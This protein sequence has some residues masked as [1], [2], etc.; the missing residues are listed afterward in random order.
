MTRVLLV[1]V[2]GSPEP[3]L[4]TAE[5][6]QPDELIFICSAPP[7]PAPSLD[8]VIGPGTPCLHVDADGIDHWRPN[9]V[10]QLGLTDFHADHQIIALADPD[11]LVAIHQQ[12]Q[13][14]C[15]ELKERFSQLELIGDYSGGTKSMSAALAMVLVD[16][17]A[18]IHL[19]TGS[20][21]NLVRLDRSDGSRPIAIGPLKA[22]RLLNDQWPQLLAS[23]FYD[24]AAH[25]LRELRLMHQPSLDPSSLDAIQ[26]LEE[27]L[28]VLMLWDQFHWQDAL[29][30]ATSSHVLNEFPELLSWWQRVDAARALLCK[31]PSEVAATGY[32]LVQDLLLNADRRGRRGWYD[33]AVAR[34]YRALEL[35]AQTYIQLELGID[36][37]SF[38]DD[39]QVQRDCQQWKIRR[40]VGGLYYWLRQ[41]EG[42]TGL[43]GAAG[44]Q[45]FQLRDLLDARNHSLLSHGLKPIRQAD[46]QALQ[47]RVNNLVTRALQ[48]AGC[49]Q[50]APPHQL[51]ADLILDLPQTRLLLGAQP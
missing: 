9:L 22:S 13:R 46:W 39:D 11:D 1:T 10:H 20:R 45:W 35:L 28:A 24:R 37:Q 44:R 47:G 21:S 25:S 40:G 38:W 34:L 33:D 41:T 23:H 43:G 31:E 6:H 29:E 7:C 19:V 4:K 32:E 48:E 12:V 5:I 3:I 15:F 16:Q 36:H 17:E 26:Q 27:G 49:Q 8:Q 50:G 18:A 42:A 14:V 2:G 30:R 51:P